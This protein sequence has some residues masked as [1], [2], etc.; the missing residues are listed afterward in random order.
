MKYLA[1]ILPTYNV[2]NDWII[3]L[4]KPFINILS[5]FN[6]T[7]RRLDY[8]YIGRHDTEQTIKWKV[9]GSAQG[10]NED[11]TPASATFDDAQCLYLLCTVH[12]QT[13]GIGLLL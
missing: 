13:S 1:L 6:V 2:L 9:C 5:F 8:I 7:S 3:H 12:G 4:D 10:L 11:T